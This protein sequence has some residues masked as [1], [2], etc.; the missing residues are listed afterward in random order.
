MKSTERQLEVPA[1][2]NGITI[3]TATFTVT[4]TETPS[5]VIAT[6]TYGERPIGQLGFA[7]GTGFENVMATI[8]NLLTPEPYLRHS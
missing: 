7:A 5:E 3:G 6:V 1:I 8:Q 2:L 4:A